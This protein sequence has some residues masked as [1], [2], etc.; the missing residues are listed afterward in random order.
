MFVHVQHLHFHWYARNI[1]QTTIVLNKL[2]ICGHKTSCSRSNTAIIDRKSCLLAD[3]DLMIHYTQRRVIIVA[4]LLL[5]GILS[6]TEVDTHVSEGRDCPLWTYWRNSSSSCVCGSSA[7]GLVECDEHTHALKLKLCACLTHDYTTNR[8]IACYCAYSCIINL[9]NPIHTVNKTSNSSETCDFFKRAGPLCSECMPGYGVPLYTYSLKCVKC[10]HFDSLK[11]IRFLL[12]SLLPPTLLFIVITVLHVHVLHPP[13]SVFILAAQA[14]STP[15]IL[16]SSLSVKH[17]VGET[18]LKF[19]ATVYGI[20][21]LDFFKALY[22][23]ECISPDYSTLDVYVIEGL[24]GLYPLFLCGLLYLLIMIRSRGYK[25]A[26]KVHYACSRFRGTLNLRES[27]IGTFATLFLLSYMKIGFA[28]CYILAIT[29]VW[30]PNGRHHSAVYIYP[31]MHYFTSSHALYA[32]VTIILALLFVI[33]PIV[34]LLF[35]PYQWFQRCLSY[36]HLRSLALNMVVDVF[37]GCYKDGTNGTRDCR[38]FAA[39]QLILRLVV[40]LSFT[41]TKEP[42]L[43]TILSSFVLAAFITAFV[44]VR[45]YKR[46]LYN[47]TDIPIL[48][49]ILCL[50]VAVNV[51]ILLEVYNYSPFDINVLG[52]IIVLTLITPLLYLAIFSILYVRSVIIRSQCC[53]RHRPESQQL[54][55]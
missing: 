24:T 8:S 1:L 31:S 5:G 22:N 16:Q 53:K 46:S 19:I 52:I 37:Q 54:L 13:I 15:V 35:Y 45:P 30:S 3:Q 4:L 29:K 55:P 34:L 39:L 49:T 2:S 18:F 33:L 26:L 20:W 43:S 11:L 32:S 7:G 36:F 12:T 41:F 14:I 47:N 9:R 28:A 21:N 51:S 50:I 23:P 6:S 44:I 17:S 25:I 42:F 40:P 48:M 38:Y 27:I 10:P